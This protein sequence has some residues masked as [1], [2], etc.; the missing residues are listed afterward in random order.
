MKLCEECGAK[1]EIKCPSC[2]A[3]IALGKKMCGECGYNL[4]LLSE[5]APKA[6]SFDEKLAKIQRYLPKDLSD[7][8]EIIITSLGLLATVGR[9][10]SL[11]KFEKL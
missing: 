8:K 4:T 2:G 10:E 1:M 9:V 6:L 7:E 5:P 3:F 11:D